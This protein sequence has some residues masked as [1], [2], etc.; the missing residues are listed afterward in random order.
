MKISST[1]NYTKP[2]PG[3]KALPSEKTFQRAVGNGE[4]TATLLK[5]SDRKT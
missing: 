1:V 5:N 4:L 2:K 3:E